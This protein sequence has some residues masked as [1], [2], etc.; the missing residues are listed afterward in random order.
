MSLVKKE[1]YCKFIAGDCIKQKCAAFQ[2]K[3]PMTEH[4]HQQY[5]MRDWPVTDPYVRNWCQQYNKQM[6]TTFS[7]KEG[8][9]S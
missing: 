8:D 7:T 1:P 5:N 6:L 4:E 2:V 9:K 3:R